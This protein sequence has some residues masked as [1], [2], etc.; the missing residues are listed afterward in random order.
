M[1]RRIEIR[2]GTFQ[3]LLEHDL[4][5]YGWSFVPALGVDLRCDTPILCDLSILRGFG[6]ELFRPFF[7]QASI[8]HKG[9]MGFVAARVEDAA[10]GEE[11][12]VA[13]PLLLQESEGREVLAFGTPGADPA[14]REQIV[15][16]FILLESAIRPTHAGTG[17]G[18]S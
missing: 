1:T 2:G 8:H 4:S 6:I 18:E 16:A 10:D 7:W 5:L 13:Y 9:P 15:A 11:I 14:V 3:R 17:S 12:E